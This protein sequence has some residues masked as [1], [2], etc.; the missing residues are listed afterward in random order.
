MTA[1]RTTIRKESSHSGDL[2]SRAASHLLLSHPPGPRLC[3]GSDAFCWEA[4]GCSGVQ[5][6]LL[7]RHC[8]CFPSLC[9]YSPA[10]SVRNSS[11]LQWLLQQKTTEGLSLLMDEPESLVQTTPHWQGHPAVV[12]T[13]FS[14]LS[15]GGAAAALW[16]TKC[17]CHLE[18]LQPCLHLGEG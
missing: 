2:L 15:Q 12:A 3:P 13:V 11:G 8:V 18:M 6:F 10:C 9:I 4:E 14:L 17:T 1:T 7:P 5:L 16:N